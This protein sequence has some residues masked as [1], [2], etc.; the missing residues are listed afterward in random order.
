MMA[1]QYRNNG[2]RPAALLRGPKKKTIRKLAVRVDYEM[3]E[4]LE[5]ACEG[6]GES[7]SDFVRIA[8]AERIEQCERRRRKGLS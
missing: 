5:R 2:S 6:L 4:R 7:T 1:N 8:L 3:N